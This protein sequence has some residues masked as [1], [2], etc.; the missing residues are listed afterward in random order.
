MRKAE[1]YPFMVLFTVQPLRFVEMLPVRPSAA[2]TGP[3]KEASDGSTI[4]GCWSES[5][6]AE[7]SPALS[8][9]QWRH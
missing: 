7:Q 4:M 3:D 8:H 1:Q 9:A 6:P 5:S 2:L